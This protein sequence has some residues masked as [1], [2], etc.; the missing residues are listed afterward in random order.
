VKIISEILL[1]GHVSVNANQLFLKRHHSGAQIRNC[2]NAP[3]HLIF[4]QQT[5]LPSVAQFAHLKNG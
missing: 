3:M 5:S 4:T 2:A 1:A